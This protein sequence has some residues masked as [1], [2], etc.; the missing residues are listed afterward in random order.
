MIRMSNKGRVISMTRS[1][2]WATII[3][4]IKSE[5][6]ADFCINHCPHKENPCNGDCPEMKEFRKNHRK[7]G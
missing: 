7:R 2:T 1:E 3:P 4:N 5:E 6:K